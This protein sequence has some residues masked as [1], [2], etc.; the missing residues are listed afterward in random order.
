MA[1][2]PSVDGV[3]AMCPR[4]VAAMCP[5]AA[6]R[7]LLLLPPPGAVAAVAAV[8]AGPNCRAVV[9]LTEFNPRRVF[10]NGTQAA[11]CRQFAHLSFNNGVE[12][13]R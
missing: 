13:V 8:A 7:I 6:A 9:S 4:A 11:I 5:R 3:A 2:G 1:R 10:V 12:G